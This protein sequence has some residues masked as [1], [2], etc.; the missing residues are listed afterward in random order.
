MATF[1]IYDAGAGGN[2]QPSAQQYPS[3]PVTA[4]QDLG[5]IGGQ[6][7]NTRA[8]DL[9]Q[10]TSF[11]GVERPR[12]NRGLLSSLKRFGNLAVGDKIG[13]IVIPKKHRLESVNVNVLNP[14]AGVTFSVGGRFTGQAIGGVVNAGSANS[15]STDITAAALKYNDT[16]NEIIEVTLATVPA[17]GLGQLAFTVSANTVMPSMAG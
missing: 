14:V 3:A 9:R 10:T 8:F 11:S 2:N 6:F 16:Q 13:M 1:D 15:V 4:T 12:S 5:N 7:P 17:G